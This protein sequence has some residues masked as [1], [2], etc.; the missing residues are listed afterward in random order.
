[1]QRNER[2]RR[3]KRCERSRE[4]GYIQL[5]TFDP[6]TLQSKALSALRQRKHQQT[7]LTKTDAQLMNLQELVRREAWLHGGFLSRH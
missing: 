4:R 1:M 3:V 6:A 2:W 5:L 7:L